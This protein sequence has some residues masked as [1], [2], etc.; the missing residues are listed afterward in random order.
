MA[1]SIY[2]SQIDDQSEDIDYEGSIEEETRI[3]KID[4]NRVRKSTSEPPSE[5]K[6]L[7]D[8]LKKCNRIQLLEELARINTWTF[9]KCELGHWKDVLNIFDS[10][11]DEATENH[12]E[13][14]W[15]LNCDWKYSN[16]DKKL[17]LWILHFTTLLI[18][19]SFSR[20][21][22]KSMTKLLTLLGSSDMCVVLGVLNLLYIFSKRSNFI[23]RMHHDQRMVLISRLH[24]L[25]ESWGG[26]ENGFGL[27]DCCDVQK[28]M[29]PSATTLHFEFHNEQADAKGKQ[30]MT[31]IHVEHVDQIRKTPAEIMKGLVSIY[32]VPVEKEMLLFTHVRL[33]YHFSNY[34]NRLLCVQARLQ[35]LS[36]L[37]YANALQDSAHTLLY[38]GLLEELVEL[39]ELKF[40]YLVE[41][42]SAALRTLTS[43]I[44]LDRN[45][46]FP[47]KPGSR[48]NNIIDVT[49]ASQYHGF[50]PV[51][52]RYC[53]S[54]LTSQTENKDNTNKDSSSTS[55]NKELEKCENAEDIITIDEEYEP[56]PYLNTHLS[57]TKGKFPQP[58]ATALFSFLYH[59]A[60][61]EAGGDALVSCG[62][63]ESL[64]QVI[65][66]HGVELEHI[67]FVTRAVRVID[68]IT[69][70][71]M[72]AFYTHGGLQSF[73]NRLDV[74][75]NL[76]VK[77][78]AYEFKY[79]PVDTDTERP[80]T[81]DST[82]QNEDTSPFEFLYNPENAGKTCLPQRA[83]LLKSMLN[84]LKKALQDTTF[85]EHIRHL[86]ETTLPNSLKHIIS[87][88]EYY[89]PSLFLLATDVV[90]V[91][92]FQE[93]SLL[94]TIQDNGLTD[95]VLQAL[96][97]KDVPATREVLASLP[98]VFSALCLNARGLASFIKC[99]PF[100][101]LFKVLL[102]PTYLSAMRKRRSS[103]PMGDA[104]S[105]LGN[106]MDELMRHQPS[107]KVDA[108]AAII[109]LLNELCQL[110]SDPKYICWRPH[111][112]TDASPTNTQ[113]TST[114]AEG[115]SDD[116]EDDDE[117]EASTSSQTAQS[118]SQESQ[119]AQCSEKTPI[120]L[121]EYILN[122][123]KFIDAI[124]S[125]NSTDDHCKEFVNQDGLVPLLKI[126]GLPNLPV[127]CPVTN[128]AQAVAS[129]CKSILNLAHEPK[130]LEQGLAQLEEVLVK[131][132]PLYSH[133]NIPGG[134]KLLHEL[135]NAPH[136][137]TAFSTESATPLLHAMGAAHGYVLMFVHVCRTSQNEIR[138]LSL[139]HWGSEKGIL[140]LKGLAELY[141]SLVWES[142]L[143]LALCSDD[144]ISSDCDFGRDDMEKLNIPVPEKPEA[145]G[146]TAGNVASAMEA[147]TTNPQ[148]SVMEVDTETNTGNKPT[149][150][151]L[152]YI[153]PLLGA[154][155]RLGRALAE[156]FGL[157]VKL[158]VGS[159]I[160]QRR[161]QN[162]VAAPAFPSPH[163]QS[164]ATALNSL[165]ANGLNS[166][167]LPPSPVPKFRLTFLICSV[168]FTSPMLFDE[169]RYPYHLMLQKFVS[170]G[171]Q[172]T[173][174]STFR[175]SLSAAGTIP[176]E[177]GIEHPNLPEGTGEFLDAWL[178]LLEKMVNPKAILDSPHVITTKSQTAFKA[179]A[180]DPLKYLIQIHRLAF[181]SVMLL[182]G[183]K[184][185]PSYGI[186]MSESMLSILRHILRGEKIIKDRMNKSEEKSL[187]GSS[188]SANSS[189]SSN[190]RGEAENVNPESLRQLMDMGFSREHAMEALMHSMSVE[191]ATDYL[192][193]NPPSLLR[194]AQA[195]M[196]ID[197][198]ED[199]QVIQ[200]I[201]MSLGE[202]GP[203][204]EVK[205]KEEEEIIPL[206]EELID[207]FTQGALQICLDLIEVIPE[208]VFKVCD[209]L[210]TIMKR[211]GQE[212][213]DRLLQDFCNML[214]GIYM[215]YEP[216]LVEDNDSLEKLDLF[217]SSV[218]SLRLAYYTHLF[219]LFFEV[220]PYFDMRG[221]C[222]LAVY[223]CDLVPRL[224]KLLY[225]A[226]KVMRRGKKAN[227]P[228]WLTPV[229]LLL[230][231]L[232]KV[233]IS[234]Q[235]KRHMHLVTIRNWKWYD[236]VSG[237]WTEYSCAN[238][239][240]INDAYWN[241]EQTT[242]ITCG[243]RR[244]T[245]SFTNM[246]QVNEESNYN[247][248]I[249]MTPVNMAL[250]R[251]VDVKPD[252]F[253]GMENEQMIL[254]EK[255]EKRC[256]PI[257]YYTTTQAVVIVRSCVKLMTTDIDKDTL[258]A[259]MRLTLKLTQDFEV[260]KVFVREGGVTCLLQLKESMSFIGFRTLA[261]LL[262][263]HT[264]EGPSTLAYA[265]EKVI[266]GRALPSTP[267]PYKE[268]VF[269]LRSLGSAVSRDPLTFLEVAK[270]TLRIDINSFRRCKSEIIT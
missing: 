60:S 161:G 232:G 252:F 81:S 245:I 30:N 14:R 94:S 143:L 222:G 198:S 126:L 109:K 4:H 59:L 66:W 240:I 149:S 84:F 138:T 178:T 110:G 93:P 224:I 130:V 111:S 202:A 82:V 182:W 250:N 102:S 184:P 90:T 140:V 117:E 186:R 67:T 135:A 57:D 151:Q 253:D 97:V 205:K 156:L 48:L 12:A 203:S 244:Y 47:K 247:R 70:I 192:L 159:P 155:S 124:L 80:S 54:C 119:Q 142:T 263:R 27:A 242:R 248:P 87:N 177:E 209:L 227:V 85:S 170:L 215:L 255:E 213:R 29:P 36:V 3:M 219:T 269:M 7:I 168:G 162:T 236:V 157:L 8:R 44:H 98:N 127:D 26:K 79:I 77:E 15:A 112:K 32:S 210:V 234:T 132:K 169:K 246:Q 237:K 5:C 115:S 73:V 116:E 241:G 103:D 163:A 23:T 46:H 180:F 88:A 61:Y 239:K 31:Y 63:M 267:P 254:T 62:M 22:Y 108:T 195:G 256:V 34:K 164:V 148:S 134:S 223:Q 211:N 49:G 11:L 21:T 107:L 33:A 137:E 83:A 208:S 65:N 167:K 113:R 114:N 185:L 123:T 153:K 68:L 176:L 147:L 91:Y 258:H 100:E 72:Q 199:D 238:N 58:L 259:I 187:D 75:V 221:P 69:N 204:T 139:Q 99:K 171:G 41:I 152:K 131:L 136:L 225:Y 160:R 190:S 166:D 133:L 76:C 179:I 42:R 188:G 120:A 125:N 118:D 121:T 45:P 106:A 55:S 261:T 24:H 196:D 1:E 183:K 212:F 71:D 249:C 144:V 172:S 96:L 43:I 150:Q 50:L 206:S 10:I 270:Q 40:P 6:A 200:A 231:S 197:M 201:A 37:V 216:S 17:L 146:D 218:N 20:H 175:W 101:R 260:A 89:G 220:P 64:L 104:A 264:F 122:V 13:N 28:P 243:R 92:V 19:H 235:R 53:I 16:S 129:V 35:A 194:V 189:G 251:C 105:N 18:E 268:L 141:T 214:T 181:E 52:V 51:L 2:Y 193:S 38:N 95:V 257:S 78:H 229:L 266:R 228:K 128:S 86:M 262:I 145:G 265:M 154:S 25:A 173:F 39:I 74:E 56:Y 233:A 174:F 217:T 230:D 226:E 191:Q 158:C 207:N 165:L 9:G